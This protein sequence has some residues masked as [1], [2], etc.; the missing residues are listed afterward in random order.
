[1][2]AV[3]LVPLFFME[4]HMGLGDTLLGA[5]GFHTATFSPKEVAEIL[6]V[7]LNQVVAWIADGRLPSRKI[8]GMT[9]VDHEV[10]RDAIQSQM[11]AQLVR[12]VKG[13]MPSFE[14]VNSTAHDDRCC[15]PGCSGL[16][17]DDYEYYTGTGQYAEEGDGV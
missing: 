2:R 13:E 4:V 14:P 17:Q 5:F 9:R 3:P 12:A 1:V 11:V 7:P 16:S 10:V 6:D 15:C 8:A